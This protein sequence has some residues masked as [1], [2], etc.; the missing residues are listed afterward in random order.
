MSSQL[1]LRL[2]DGI[3]PP[4]RSRDDGASGGR[5]HRRGLAKAAVAGEI[6]GDV[7]EIDRPL[8]EGASL[9]HP[10]RSATRTP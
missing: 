10:D 5:G 7:V 2:P 1:E 4:G 8:Q 9:P 3:D 6:E